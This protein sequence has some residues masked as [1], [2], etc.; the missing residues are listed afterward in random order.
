VN[1][2]SQDKLKTPLDKPAIK[3]VLVWT[4]G[5]DSIPVWDEI[6]IWAIEQFGLPGN[7]FEWHPT[8]DDMEFYF[9]NERDA[10]HFELRWG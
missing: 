2:T 7:R 5:R 6:C 10:I 9:Y 3:V 4:K 8:E 1:Q